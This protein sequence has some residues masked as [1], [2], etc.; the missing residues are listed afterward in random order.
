[1]NVI[2]KFTFHYLKVVMRNQIFFSIPLVLITLSMYGGVVY[3][4]KRES[5]DGRIPARFGRFQRNIVDLNDSVMF[6]F[7]G[8]SLNTILTLAAYI[9]ESKGYQRFIRVSFIIHSY[10][11]W[12]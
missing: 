8:I 11:F 12:C 6:L 9:G 10:M 3:Y 5:K 1:M 7:I 2:E 4:V